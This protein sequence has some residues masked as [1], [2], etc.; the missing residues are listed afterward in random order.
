MA[1]LRYDNNITAHILTK[2]WLDRYSVEIKKSTITESVTLN[3]RL[4]YKRPVIAM[5]KDNEM[6]IYVAQVGVKDISK[7]YNSI[8][9]EFSDSNNQQYPAPNYENSLV[10]P[11]IYPDTEDLN[12]VLDDVAQDEDWLQNVQ[13]FLIG[14]VQS[15][16]CQTG[17]GKFERSRDIYG[18]YDTG[19]IVGG[20]L[21]N[22]RFLT[23]GLANENYAFEWVKRNGKWCYA[24]RINLA[25]MSPDVQFVSLH[26]VYTQ[27]LKLDWF[28]YPLFV[29]DI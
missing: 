10:F 27:Q 22:E 13:Q 2:T 25:Y 6:K 5:P 17:F 1:Q 19:R 28:S 7:Y 20:V 18:I 9:W 24:I 4:I 8:A 11:T 29:N 14:S 12:N 23:L 3:I 26:D 16:K 15:F 21:A